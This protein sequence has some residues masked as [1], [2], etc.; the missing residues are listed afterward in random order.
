[1]ECN[2]YPVID[3]WNL[4]IQ[5]PDAADFCLMFRAP[6]GGR[7]ASIAV[8]AGLGSGHCSVKINDIGVA[9]LVN[10]AFNTAVKEYSAEDDNL[11]S[12]GDQIVFAMLNG[13]NVADLRV[14]VTYA[15]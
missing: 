11:F 10:V 7:I 14:T 13:V 8:K 5:Q 6:Y 3:G 15:R 2:S 1:M 4:H 9:G 12:P